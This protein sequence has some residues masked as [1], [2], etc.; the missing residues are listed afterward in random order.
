[1]AAHYGTAILPARPRKPR[2]KALPGEP[3]EYSEWRVRRV[4]VTSTSTPKRAF[5]SIFL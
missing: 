3:Y 4:G 5:H 1:M 2:D